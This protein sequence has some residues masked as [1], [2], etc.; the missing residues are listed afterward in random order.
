MQLHNSLLPSA[1]SKTFICASQYLSCNVGVQHS[2]EQNSLKFPVTK[3]PELMDNKYPPQSQWRTEGWGGVQTPSKIPSLKHPEKA[4]Q[5][6]G[7][8]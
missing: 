1:S 8:W 5:V 4:E 6:S 7:D 2:G 3:R